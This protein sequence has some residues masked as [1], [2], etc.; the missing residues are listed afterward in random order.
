MKNEKVFEV[1]I[2][3]QKCNGTGL[4]VGAAE[5][6][7]AA[8]VCRTCKGTGK[9][10]HK[11]TYTEFTNRTPRDDV[12]RVFKTSCGYVHTAKD[13]VAEGKTIEFSKGGVSYS[14]WLAGGDPK[15]LKNLYCP[16]QFTGQSWKSPIHCRDNF[17]CG[18]IPDCPARSRMAECWELYENREQ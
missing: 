12:E 10:H 9:Y 3:C 8:V 7:G 4:Y 14:E 2:E 5:R 13:V 6:D 11:F 15:P 18:M 17:F 1:D 16:L